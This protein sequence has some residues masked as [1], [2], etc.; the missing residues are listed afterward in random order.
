[1]CVRVSCPH[2][3]GFCLSAC[4]SDAAAFCLL[5]CPP[6]L[7]HCP[8]VY[9]AR[10]TVSCGPRTMGS[11]MVCGGGRQ[12]PTRRA[13]R[14]SSLA[15]AQLLINAEPH[16]RRVPVAALLWVTESRRPREGTFS[17][18][19]APRAQTKDIYRTDGYPAGPRTSI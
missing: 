19:A 10:H 15:G 9:S 7:T 18:P 12:V 17:R 3:R 14:Y 5:V 11:F 16:Q 13:A 8:Y 1:M 4:T 6:E 2:K